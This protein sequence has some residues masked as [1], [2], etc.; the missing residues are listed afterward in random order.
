LLVTGFAGKGYHEADACRDGLLAMWR[1]TESS[2]IPVPLQP[3]AQ[4]TFDLKFHPTVDW[5]ATGTSVP[6]MG[7]NGTGKHIRSLVRIY[8]PLKKTRCAIE[9]DCPALDINDVSF[10]PMDRFYISASCTDGVTYVWDFRNPSKILHQLPHGDALNQLDEQLT[11]EQADVGVRVALWG[12]SMDKFLTGG[13]D[14]VLRAWDIRLAPE[15]VHLREVVTIQD[16]IMSGAFSPDKSAL[17]I[18]DAAGG[19]HLLNPAIDSDPVKE[20]NYEHGDS[21]A[22]MSN[23]PSDSGR[24]IGR[25]LLR[26]GQLIQH[27]KYGVGQGPAYRGPYAS[28]ARPEGTPNDR[29]AVTPLLREIQ[30]LQLD[31]LPSTSPRSGAVSSRGTVDMQRKVAEIR[32]RDPSV[33]KRRHA[34]EHELIKRSR[35][36][37]IIDLCSDDGQFKQQVWIDLTNETDIEKSDE[38]ASGD[39]D[40]DEDEDEEDYWFPE[41]CNVDPNIRATE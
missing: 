1:M 11:R 9:F 30:A 34:I 13:S 39:Y 26:T 18:G 25:K 22:E 38:S 24:E 31:Q 15:D 7:T 20:F 33:R 4:N 16:E 17:L 41:S 6:A 29:I 10:C 14:G 23:A 12:E 40:A 28:W 21:S 37:D 27:P 8:E 5:L 19:I 2:I 35:P 36:I 32:N 3:N